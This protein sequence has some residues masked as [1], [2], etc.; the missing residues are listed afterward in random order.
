MQKIDNFNT[1]YK[2]SRAVYVQNG[3]AFDVIVY[4]ERFV[5]GHLQYKIRPVSGNGDKWVDEQ[6]IIFREKTIKAKI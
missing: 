6:S 4:L 2:K 3:M 5:F 1:R